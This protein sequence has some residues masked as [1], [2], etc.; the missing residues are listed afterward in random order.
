ML[1]KESV[2]KFKFKFSDINEDALEDYIKFLKKIRNEQEKIAKKSDYEDIAACDFCEGAD[3]T[4]SA[5]ES[6]LDD[7]ESGEI[8]EEE[9]IDFLDWSSRQ[10]GSSIIAEVLD[11]SGVLKGITK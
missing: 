1:K 3:G 11:V 6:V 9:F 5:L 7:A 10:A 2:N 8:T 4:I